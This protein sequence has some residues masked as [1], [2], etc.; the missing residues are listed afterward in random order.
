MRTICRDCRLFVAVIVLGVSSFLIGSAC[1]AEKTWRAGFARVV[2]TPEK[3]MFASGYGAR[4]KPSSGKVHDLHVRVA[5]MTDAAGHSVVFISM[6]LISVPRKM[7][8]MICKAIEKKHGVKRAN[9]M[10]CCSHTHCGPALDEKLTHMLDLKEADW[11]LILANQKSLNAKVLAAIDEAVANQKPARLQVGQGT[12]GFGVNR[13]PPIGEGPTDHDVPVLL[14][15]SPDGKTVR[16]II[17]GY[18]CHNTTLSFYQWC[19]DYAG[20]AQINLE[21]R[22]PKAVA[23]FFTG[24]GADQNPLPRRKV[25]LAQ[26]YGRML[27]EAVAKVVSGK[28]KSVDGPIRTAFRTISLKLDKIPPKSQWEQD[29]EKGTRYQKARARLLLKQIAEHGELPQTHPYPVQIWQLVDRVTWVALGG[30]VVVDYSLRLK[31][32]LGKGRTWVAGYAN[33]VMAYIPSERVLREGGYEGGRS[34]LY[35]QLPAHWKP[36]LEDQI[37]NTVKSLTKSLRAAK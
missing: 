33:H 36:G 28:M 27:S 17:F 21:D 14:V 20:F 6:D 11:K 4:G 16:G 10:I 22:F 13:R 7:A 3:P 35:Y 19:G 29:L 8:D 31:R 15:T 30:E 12:T 2:I 23:L 9:V 26:K 18:A 24:C 34:M 25:E 32:E 37:V 5:A 1:G